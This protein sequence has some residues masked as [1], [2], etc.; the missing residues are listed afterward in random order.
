MTIK[1]LT[2]CD[3]SRPPQDEVISDLSWGGRRSRDPSLDNEA[4]N[5]VHLNRSTP[6]RTPF[7]GAGGGAGRHIVTGSEN[8]ARFPTLSNPLGADDLV[9]QYVNIHSRHSRETYA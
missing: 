5:D 7:L 1:S 2:I 9:S 3:W 4:R 8:G 6:L